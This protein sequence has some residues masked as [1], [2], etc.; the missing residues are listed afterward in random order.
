MRERILHTA[1][2]CSPGTVT[3]VHPG[4]SAVT[5]YVSMRATQLTALLDLV[6]D[7]G[8]EV[9]VQCDDDT[10]RGVLWLASTL[11]NEVSDLILQQPDAPVS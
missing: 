1:V 10:Q 4:Y 11:A 3:I 8:L 9:F 6:H 7:Q 2:A 5:D